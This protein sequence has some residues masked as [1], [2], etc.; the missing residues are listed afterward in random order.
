M[1]ISLIQS[2]ANQIIRERFFRY[3]Y[4]NISESQTFDALLMASGDR[5]L[6]TLSLV[7]EADNLDSGVTWSKAVA[8]GINPIRLRT[9]GIGYNNPYKT[10]DDHG[11]SDPLHIAAY[12]AMF[13]SEEEA[14]LI[15]KE[16]DALIKSRNQWAAANMPEFFRDPDLGRIEW[17]RW[18][19]NR[20]MKRTWVIPD[21]EELRLPRVEMDDQIDSFYLEGAFTPESYSR[22]LKKRLGPQNI[23][24]FAM[25]SGLKNRDILPDIREAAFDQARKLCTDDKKGGFRYA[26]MAVFIRLCTPQR[27][28]SLFDELQGSRKVVALFRSDTSKKH[29]VMGLRQLAQSPQDIRKEILKHIGRAPTI[30]EIRAVR[31]IG[32]VHV[33]DEM[34]WT[35][36][37]PVT[38]QP[39]LRAAALPYAEKLGPVVLRRFLTDHPGRVKRLPSIENEADLAAKNFRVTGALSIADWKT[40]MNRL[41]RMNRESI[42]VRETLRNITENDTISFLALL[43]PHGVSSPDIEN[44]LHSHPQWKHIEKVLADYTPPNLANLWS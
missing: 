27:A 4:I 31:S 3:G 26:D 9:A 41:H 10:D 23:E 32:I 33:L 1:V 39:G 20:N 24:V 12:Y 7:Q 22:L 29:Y 21:F 28:A 30:D 37:E 38:K 36:I 40:V 19:T 16:R 35:L 11:L 15:I 13:G 25:I 5:L 17:G 43:K 18:V 2:L 8:Y 6:Q 42:M 44:A 14:K 34:D